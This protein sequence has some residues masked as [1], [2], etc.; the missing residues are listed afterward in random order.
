MSYKEQR[1]WE[2]IEEEIGALEDT[3]GNLEAEIETSASNY[4]RLNELME[5]KAQKEAALEEKMERWMYL[6]E[7]AEKIA[8]QK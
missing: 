6:N 5:D 3:I 7:L 1:E 2:T 8:A 4:S